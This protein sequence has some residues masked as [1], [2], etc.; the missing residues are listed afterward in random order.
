M[1]DDSGRQERNVWHSM[2]INIGKSVEL[3]QGVRRE[4]FPTVVRLQ[5]LDCCLRV[6]MDAP[7]F[8]AAFPGMQGPIAE[9]GELQMFSSILRQGIDAVVGEG[10]FIDE[11]I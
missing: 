9:D 5:P 8:V 10:E 7:D 1:G 11:A 4:L 6:R 3:P 2:L